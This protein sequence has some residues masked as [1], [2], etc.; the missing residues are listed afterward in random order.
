MLDSISWLCICKMIIN[1]IKLELGNSQS[2]IVVI[3]IND[4]TQYWFTA[5]WLWPL[6][7]DIRAESY[8]IPSFSLLRKT[9]I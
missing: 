6:K 5:K 1:S 4:V 2:W 9:E 3:K 7:F 8:T